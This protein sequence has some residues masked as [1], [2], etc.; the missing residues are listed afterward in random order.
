MAIL[1]LIRD[2]IEQ[3]ALIARALDIAETRALDIH[4]L[5]SVA[6]IRATTGLPSEEELRQGVLQGF[7]EKSEHYAE[8]IERTEKVEDSQLPF[9]GFEAVAQEGLDEEAFS[10]L[11]HRKIQLLIVSKLAVS[12]SK[13]ERDILVERLLREG[14]ADALLLRPDTTRLRKPKKILVSISGGPHAAIA[15]RLAADM[16]DRDEGRVVA[17]H[18][19][20]DRMDHA[21]EFAEAVLKKALRAAKI[22]DRVTVETKTVLGSDVKAC[23]TKEASDGVDL[24]LLGASNR[25]KIRRILFG[26]IPDSV[27]MS[28]QMQAVGVVCAACPLIIR[29]QRQLEN[30]IDCRIPQMSRDDRLSL[31]ERLQTGSKWNFDF[32]SLMCLST[33]IAALGLVQN[34]TAVVIGAMLVAPL[35]TPLLGAGLSLVQGNSQLLGTSL[36]SVVMGFSMALCL[37]VLVGH[38]SGIAFAGSEILGRGHPT[39]L[40][41]A[42]AGF[43]GIAAAYCSSRPGLSAALPGVAIAAALVPP[44]ASSGIA[45][46]LG[47]YDLAQGAALLFGTNVTAIICGASLCFYL[48]G[49]RGQSGEGGPHRVIWRGILFFLFLCAM[50]AVPLSENQHKARRLTQ[51]EYMKVQDVLRRIDAYLLSGEVKGDGASQTLELVVARESAP[52]SSQ[53]SQMHHELKQ[54]GLKQQQLKLR[55]HIE[56]HVVAQ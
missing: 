23:I 35:M 4:V 47:H 37:G 13:A 56:H 34:S 41:L 7:T 16:V 25:G 55:T 39:L 6:Q 36:R 27:L 43:S 32:L 12:K 46:S 14:S 51:F 54:S 26:T 48:A 31:F 45:L 1:V 18:V 21:H 19:E 2:E 49:V 17:L 9:V 52:N 44:I 28:E 24:V 50:L 42:V 20:S 40:D 33:T 29:M 53:V 10:I 11:K 38:V 3:C 5:V 30:W 8:L 15:L 22:E